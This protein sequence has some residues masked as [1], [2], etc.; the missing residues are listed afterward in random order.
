MTLDQ[1]L[2]NYTI[3]KVKS[4]LPYTQY[5]L[6]KNYDEEDII[7]TWQEDKHRLSY[8][9]TELINITYK[10]PYH[11]ILVAYCITNNY[12]PNLCG[13]PYNGIYWINK[14]YHIIHFYP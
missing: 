4:S 6:P 12:I 11:N 2:H 10:K 14:E 9:P 3:K 13:S 5:K 8:T 7:T 1:L